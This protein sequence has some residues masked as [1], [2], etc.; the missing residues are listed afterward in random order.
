MPIR[1]EETI[2]Q[3]AYKHKHAMFKKHSFFLI[4]EKGI[5]L[6]IRGKT[7]NG[8]PFYRWFKYGWKTFSIGFFRDFT[9]KY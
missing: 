5:V 6:Q 1:Q 7:P 3:T 2:K 8:Y 9:P 4:N